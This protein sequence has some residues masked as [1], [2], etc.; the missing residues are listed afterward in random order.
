MLRK[1]L[2]QGLDES[3]KLKETPD[4]QRQISVD[5]IEKYSKSKEFKV[6]ELSREWASRFASS[7]VSTD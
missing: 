7:L 6:S 3:M 2:E 4:T 5:I 1:T